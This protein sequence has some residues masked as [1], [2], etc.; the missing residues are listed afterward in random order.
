MESH[1]DQHRGK[2]MLAPLIRSLGW[3]VALA[4]LLPSPSTSAGE[5]T[6]PASPDTA[7][8]LPAKEWTA[9]EDHQNMLDQLGIKTLRR[10][11]DGMNPKAPNF[12]NTDE[13]K[14]NPWPNLPDP[15]RLK[16]GTKVTMAEAWWKQRRP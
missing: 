12:Q 10:G 7:K 9:K 6:P 15:L 14:A 5:E 1:R 11:A 2:T 13:S 16:N 8:P 4:L 3:S